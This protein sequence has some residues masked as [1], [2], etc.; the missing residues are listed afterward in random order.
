MSV[1]QQNE[2]EREQERRARIIRGIS[3]LS[4]DEVR[5]IA[6]I[7]YAFRSVVLTSS[8]KRVLQ[9]VWARYVGTEST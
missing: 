2:A 1:R 8:R 4:D 3:R 7:Q 9:Y 5:A 6:L